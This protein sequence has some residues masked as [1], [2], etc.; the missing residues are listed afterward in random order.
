ME[1][2]EGNKHR[3]KLIE[4]TR[5]TCGEGVRAQFMADKVIKIIKNYSGIE[6]NIPKIERQLRTN[7]KVM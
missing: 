7:K 4:G 2:G 5:E 1:S 6:K 3:W